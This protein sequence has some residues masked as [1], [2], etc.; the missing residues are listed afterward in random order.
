MPMQPGPGFGPEETCGDY[1]GRT[2]AGRP[3]RQPAGWK[4]DDASG[5]CHQ[6]D[7]IHEAWMV[8]KKAE[9]I[10]LL[11]TTPF[12]KTLGELVGI[13]PKTIYDWRR[14]DGKFREEYD[15]LVEVRDKERAAQVEDK[16][17]E[18]IMA[19]KA[20][21]AETIFFLKNRD[22]DRWKEQFTSPKAQTG[23]TG[24]LPNADSA[25]ARLSKK[26]KT[27]ARRAAEATRAVDDH[28]EDHKSD[29]ASLT[30]R[31]QRE[32]TRTDTE[33]ADDTVAE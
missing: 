19:D 11:P 1:G 13:P 26:L 24:D 22:P 7:T 10:E 6:H 30:E 18:R 29:V 27:M 12:L 2:S 33:T 16:V 15:A 14:S 4:S 9:I 17:Y 23:A 3:C 8:G 31:L 20:S 21:P 28:A 5:R 25:K 32:I